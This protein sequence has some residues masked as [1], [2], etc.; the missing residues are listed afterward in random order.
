MRYISL[1]S[2]DVVLGFISDRKGA[3]DVSVRES[4]SG[5]WLRE[6]I[7]A[8]NILSSGS[9]SSEYM[10]RL[11]YLLGVA[12]LK[13]KQLAHEGLRK[14]VQR[15]RLSNALVRSQLML[16]LFGGRLAR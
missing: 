10:N 7:A 16:E 12:G 11:R 4:K 6:G 15:G 3:V 2:G 8:K 9:N 1:R 5:S 14:A 13:P